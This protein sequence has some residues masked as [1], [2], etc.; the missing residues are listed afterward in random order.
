MPAISFLGRGQGP[1]ISSVEFITFCGLPNLKRRLYNTEE[2]LTRFGQFAPFAVVGVLCL[3][4]GPEPEMLRRVLEVVQR[5]QPML[6]MGIVEDGR[7]LYFESSNDVPPI[8][9]RL[10]TRQD[11]QHWRQLVTEALNTTVEFQ[12]VPLL[13]CIY[14]Y[15]A[16]RRDRAEIIFIAHHAAVDAASLLPLYHELLFLCA[17]R[18]PEASPLVGA[19]LPAAEQLFPSRMRGLKRYGRLLSYLL[20]Q[21]GDERNYRVRLAQGRRVP[22]HAT[23]RCRILTRTLDENYTKALI[24]QSRR[25]RVTM[26]SVVSAAMLLAVRR[27]LYQDQAQPLRAMAFVDLRP[28]LQPSVPN[29]YLGCYMAMMRHTIHWPEQ[30]GFWPSVHAFQEV[31]TQSVRRDEHFAAAL[32]SKPMYQMMV[33][34][35]P[36]RLAATAV[37]YVGPIRLLPAYGSIRLTGLHGFISNNRLGPEY[38]AFASIL[39]GRLSW[40]FLY[41]DT[42][43]EQPLAAAIADEINRILCQAG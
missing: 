36:S 38:S 4:N 32:M 7:H 12:T 11:E 6:Q 24:R 3:Q 30:A 33:R 21:V 10:L 39:N 19:I 25:Q 14:L 16:D 20:R 15:P 13:R 17:G 23:A 41:L 26:Y 28:Y 40:D 35:Q 22:I 29:D 42:D 31:I 34:F 2:T 27:H 5:R 9:L 18:V 43:M 8:P 37:S 1:Q